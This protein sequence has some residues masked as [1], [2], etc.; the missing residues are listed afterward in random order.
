MCGAF[1][2]FVVK[3]YQ[4]KQEITSVIKESPVPIGGP[5]KMTNHLGQVTTHKDFPNKYLLVYFGYTFCPDICPTALQS[6]T[7]ALNDLGTRAQKFQPLFVTVDPQ[8]DQIQNLSEFVKDFHPSLI[9]L[10]GTPQQTKQLADAYKIYYAV[11]NPEEEHYLIDHTSLIYVMNPKGEYVTHFRH[12]T[13]VTEMKKI[14]K[15][16]PL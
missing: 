1:T 6:L 2:F 16:V 3:S 5:F 9:A 15:R 7:M 12:N 10:R 4:H 8:R 13:S 14:L 11:V